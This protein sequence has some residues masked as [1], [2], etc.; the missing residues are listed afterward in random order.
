LFQQH[1]YHSLSQMERELLHLD[2]GTALETLYQERIGQ[3][4]PHLAWHFAQ[5][6]ESEKAIDYALQAGVQE[7]G[8][9]GI[10]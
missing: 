5:A 8:L 4:A 2:V 7:R 1:L 9:S 6:A 3:I 10:L